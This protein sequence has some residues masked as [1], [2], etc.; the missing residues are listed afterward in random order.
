MHEIIRSPHLVGDS[1]LVDIE[2]SESNVSVQFLD[3]YPH[4]KRYGLG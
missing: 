3:V 1:F 2:E 4:R